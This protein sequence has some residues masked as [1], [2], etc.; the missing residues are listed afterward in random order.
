MIK[1]CQTKLA[2]KPRRAHAVIFYSQYPDGVLDRNSLHGACPVIEGTKWAANLWIWNK[3]RLGY[4]GA[5][6]KQGA[7]AYDPNQA[8]SRDRLVGKDKVTV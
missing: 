6:R 1:E 8:V 3:V 2:V 7:K 5:P 4:A